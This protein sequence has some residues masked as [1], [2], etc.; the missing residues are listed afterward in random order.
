MLPLDMPSRSQLSPAER[1]ALSRLRQ[2]LAEPGVVRGNLVEMKRRCG[3]KQCCCA[4]D[5]EGRHRSLYLGV[6]IDGHKRM[7]Y[8]PAEWEERLRQWTGRY[9]EIRQLLDELSTE[10]LRRLSERE[11]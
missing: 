5:P 2:L 4:T 11:D 9:A 1:K 6:S 7:I 8:I 10:A 3:K